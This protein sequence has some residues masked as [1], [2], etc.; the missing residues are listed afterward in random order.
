MKRK[1]FA[2]A[3][4]LLCLALLLSLPAAALTLGE[5][6]GGYSVPA[7]YGTELARGVYWTGD[8]YRT[9][10]YIERAPD[11]GVFPIAVGGEMLCGRGSLAD[12]A[13][14]LEEAGLHVLAGVNG[15]FFNMRS[16]IPAG[17]C[18]ENGVLRSSCDGVWAVG[19][20]ADGSTLI[21]KPALEMNLEICGRA[22]PLTVLNK[23]RGAAL[24]LYT[25][26]FAD[27]TPDD[28][29]GRVFVCTPSEK[30]KTQG[31]LTLTVE[32]CADAEGAV[33]IPEGKAILSLSVDANEWMQA[34]ADA[35]TEGSRQTLSL[36]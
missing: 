32:S 27:R 15:D 12:T 33:S 31:E 13:A 1:S 16:G 9:E 30:P 4:L 10:N 24:A 17:I 19:F 36:S 22:Y 35:I 21:G 11:S 34:A 28:G 18:V 7:S 29:A 8:D 3:A 6:I 5:P 23:N 14:R 25:D 26:D 20:R 2:G